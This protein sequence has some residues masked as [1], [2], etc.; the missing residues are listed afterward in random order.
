M[1]MFRHYAQLTSK[2]RPIYVFTGVLAEVLFSV[3][4]HGSFSPENKGVWDPVDKRMEY[5]GT[6]EEVWYWTAER[7]A[8]EFTAEILQ[9]EESDRG[10]YWNVY[11]GAQS[12]LE[13]AKTYE[14]VRGSVNVEWK[15]TV[16]NLKKDALETRSK[17]RNKFQYFEY[18]CLFYQL[19]TTDGTYHRPYL[20]NDKLHVKTTSLEEFLKQNPTV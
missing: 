8:A 10:G 12:L 16:G 18:C 13:I 15:G 1:L 11:S 5:Y 17:A 14:R 19:Y 7:D 4:G 6:G 2:I 20:M 3:P 9:L